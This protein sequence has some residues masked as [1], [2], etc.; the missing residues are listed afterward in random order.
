M[1]SLKPE[2]KEMTS[3]ESFK[4]E[5]GKS[6]VSQVEEEYRRT[7][8][9]KNLIQ[10]E[11]HNANKDNTYVKGVNQFADLTQEEFV[12]TYL[13]TKVNPKFTDSESVVI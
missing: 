11:G 9:L 7:V 2:Q 8:F 3:F 6:Y 12:A 1:F 4:K 10:I 5:F 13:N